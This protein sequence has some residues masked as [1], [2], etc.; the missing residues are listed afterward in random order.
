[1]SL[2][3]LERATRALRETT[4]ASDA[5]ALDRVLERIERPKPS[6]GLSMRHVRIVAWT[7]A[8]S[9]LGVGAW[10]NVT[11]RVSWFVPEPARAPEPAAA[12]PPAAPAP[13]ERARRRAPAPAGLEQPEVVDEPAPPELAPEVVP[14]APVPDPAP[15]EPR[16][17]TPKRVAPVAPSAT[18][19]ARPPARLAPPAPDADSLYRAA[20]DAHFARADYAE[21][22]ALWDR[23]L[24]A[25]EPGQ[26][27][28][29]EARYNRGIAL[30]RLGKNDAAREALEP[31]ARGEYGSYRRSDARRLLDA[32]P[33]PSQPARALPS[34]D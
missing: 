29:I 16:R 15:S 11:G 5:A 9:L 19:E 32:L 27:W 17:D 6:R 14:P 31:F 2:D 28:T 25:A 10:A 20:H 33:A 30:Y 24:A 34:A 4:D 13:R 21:A 22:L 12:A 23:Y 1:V 26:R 18:R 7:L 8:S 3:L